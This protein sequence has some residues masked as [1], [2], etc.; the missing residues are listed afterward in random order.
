MF[1]GLFI[2][3]LFGSFVELIK[4]RNE[5]IVPAENWTNKELY[6]KDIMDGVPIEQC[7][8]NLNNGKYKLTEAHPEPH[9]DKDGK[10][11]IE[12]CKLYY[13]DIDKYGAYKTYQWAEKGRYNLSSEELK[14]EKERIK[15]HYDDLCK[16]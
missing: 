9:R 10:I 11:I 2:A 14:K 12:N 1:D 13:E 5:P 15:R 4:E 16:L 8:K 7:L 6:D 3:S